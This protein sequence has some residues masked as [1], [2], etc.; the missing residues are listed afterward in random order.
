MPGDITFQR[1]IGCWIIQDCTPEGLDV[2]TKLG[3]AEGGHV[4]DAQYGTIIQYAASRA[5][6]LG[7]DITVHVR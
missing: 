6:E 4:T 7:I 2:I 3:L 1:D 5:A